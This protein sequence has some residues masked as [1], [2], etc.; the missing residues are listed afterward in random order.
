MENIPDFESLVELWV[1]LF[2]RSESASVAGICR[3]FWQADW[4]QGI[5]RRAI[6]D[7]AR[8]RFPIQCKPL[9][10]L[11]RSMTASGFLDT[12]PL[13]TAD[14]GFEGESPNDD[15]ELCAQHVLFYLDKL[16]TY[17]QV[18]PTAACTGS[19]ALYEKLPERLISSTISTGPTY[20]NLRPI[21]LPGGSTLPAKSIG[22]LL[23]GDAGDIIVVA[24]QHEHSG[25]KILLEILTDYVNRRRK[26]SNDGYHDFS[27]GRAVGVQ[28]QALRLEDIGVEIEGDGDDGLVTDV[29][30]LVRGVVQDHAELAE[31][32]L[33][34]LESG[35]SVVSHSMLE[36]QPPDLVQLTTMI[37]DDALSRASPQH[38]NSPCTQLITS[39]M[40]V[41]AALLALP[42]YSNRVWLYIRST[43]SLFGSERSIG[44]TSTVLAAER[45][46]GHYTMT[47]AL[48]HL[49]RQLFNEASSSV[50]TILQESP[51]LQQVKEE[52]LMRAAR[53]VHSEIW[54]EHAGW[55]YA[56]LG[57]R[58][59]IGRRVSTFYTDVLKHSPP[60]LKDG[61][62]VNLS[63]A[64]TEALVSRA[65]PSAVNPLVLALT[66]SSTVLNMLFASRRYGDARRLIYMLESHLLLIRM[67]LNYKQ[68]SP[69]S[70][71]PCLLEQALCTRASTNASSLDAGSS[72]VDPVD[73][74]ATY[75]KERGMG[76]AVPVEAVEVLFALCS[77]LSC[78]EGSAPT[79]IG[80]LSD[81]EGTVSSLVRI[82]LHPYDDALL[83]NAVW[84]FITLAV[85]KEPALA[86]LFVTGQFRNPSVK[87]K[88]KA[89][90]DANGAPKAVSAL[91][92]ACNMLEQWQELWELNPQLLASLLRFLDVVWEH[93]HEHKSS[94]ATIRQNA[95][96]FGHLASIIKEELG[97]IPDY[98]T[99]NFMLVDGV[100]HSDLH[101]G[102][103]AHSYRT[104]VKAH[105]VHILALDIRMASPSQAASSST[106]PVS[107]TSIQEIFTTEDEVTELIAESASGAYDPTLYDEAKVLIEGYFP[108]LSLEHL[109]LQDPLVEREFGDE[110]TFSPTLL[111]F[112]LQP[113]SVM[114][115]ERTDDLLKILSSINLNLS[116]AQAQMTLTESWQQLLLQVVPFL[117]G[118]TTVRPTFMLLASTISNDIAIEKRLGDMMS[119]IHNARLS[120]LLALLEVAWFST[121]DTPDEVKHFIELVNNVR[122]IVLNGYQPPAKSFLGQ[123]TVPFH[124]PLLQI[125]Y[126]CTRH[127]RSL[128]RRPKALNADQRLCVG[129]MLET[130]LNL[131]IGALR[132]VFDAALRSLDVD[133]DQDMQL[134]VAVFE[135][136]TRPDL[137]PS[138]VSWLTKC[139]ETDVVRVSLQLSSRMDVVGFSD[140]GLLRTRKQPLYAPHVFIFHMALAGVPSAAERLASE[141][142]LAAYAGNS[143]SNAISSGLLDV[144]LPELPGERNPAHQSYCSMLAVVSGVTIALSSHG[145]YFVSDVCGLVQLYSEQIHRALSWT[146]GDTLT[147]A[148]LD[149]IEQSV[150]LFSAIAMT[151]RASGDNEAVRRTLSM[152]TADALLLLQQLNYALTHHNH[153]ASLFEPIT[154][155]ERTAYETDSSNATSADA[156]SDMVD[157][158]KRPFLAR[159]VH[160]LFKISGSI[161]A[162]LVNISRGEDVLRK[163]P[164]EWSID[165]ALIVPVSVNRIVTIFRV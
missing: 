81:P 52:V 65:T 123:L 67:L 76:S 134:L 144:V 62:F 24:W 45:L 49:V 109:R 87:G 84:N 103:S 7:V 131:V 32:L 1:A 73:A 43:A 66:T 30:D 26:A 83:R 8:T 25:W 27:F 162:A 127:A 138:T 6:L 128:N 136:A 99:E 130:T 15:R 58:F 129:G 108:T 140:L 150:T 28:P 88:E 36:A 72:K 63:Q 158:V 145:R 29:L 151:S 2:G 102:V 118:N 5:A 122:G 74:L 149:E 101:E 155:E 139:Q 147:L 37:L 152:F 104:I 96:F 107:Y 17:T 12:D 161:V 54:V 132:I 9:I 119:A 135:Q 21:K 126:F 38:R 51:R 60:E 100:Q 34:S 78:Y 120:L 156:S 48:L 4:T 91:N 50:L 133:L 14:H 113:Y 89:T 11:L 56:Q 64:V 137:N 86:G 41:L 59:E 114:L 148:L 163:E 20:T 121:I 16:P 40:S 124:R 146:I 47:L 53:F 68:R 22:R 143:I 115:E 117:R 70:T 94:L 154:A 141:G 33:E 85:D 39:A 42:K 159:L 55:K 19:H 75:A 111:Q 93:R 106:K 69:I 57:D 3:Q 95:D 97:P 31:R 18:I 157:L 98:K 125:A 77:S 61:P 90:S 10:R 44:F 112:R 160:R 79:I 23:N 153:L 116:L 35:D 105:A 13:S 110:F 46:T 82:V 80:H 164:D 165:Q 142:V 71:K 92:V